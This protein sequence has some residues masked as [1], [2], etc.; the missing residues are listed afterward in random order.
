MLE[1]LGHEPADDGASRND[2]D[3]G[4]EQ[5]AKWLNSAYLNFREFEKSQTGSSRKRD[6][7]TL[8]VRDGYLIYN[9]YFAYYSKPLLIALFLIFVVIVPLANLLLGRK[10]IE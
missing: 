1:Y 9:L 5:I 3:R 2:L 8:F 7:K 10:R 4:A 6:R